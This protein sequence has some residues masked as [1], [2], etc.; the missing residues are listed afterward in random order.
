MIF[1]EP[2][3]PSERGFNIWSGGQRGIE[4][5]DR[6]LVQATLTYE[7]GV[8]DPSVETSAT[9]F[10]VPN[11]VGFGPRPHPESGRCEAQRPQGGRALEI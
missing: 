6:S 3:C 2:P 4:F 8:G 10:K 7:L 5:E 9:L 1:A 11:E